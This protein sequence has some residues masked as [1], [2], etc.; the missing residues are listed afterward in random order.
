MYVCMVCRHACML[1]IL[2]CPYVMLGVCVCSV[3]RR[4]CVYVRYVC[5]VGALCC[6]VHVRC[7]M[8]GCTLCYMCMLGDA[9][10]VLLYMYAFYVHVCACV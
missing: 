5:N 1:Y 8:S 6:F 4:V 2:V 10:S 9:M 7:G 3:G